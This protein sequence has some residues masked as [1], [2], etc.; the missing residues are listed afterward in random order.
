MEENFLIKKEN[1]KILT[2]IKG[3]CIA[4][5]RITKE[6]LKVKYMYREHP[7]SNFN[8][9]GW[10]FFAGDEGEEYTKNS[11]N[12]NIFE[13]NTICNYDDQI[14]PNLDA[15]IGSAFVKEQNGKFIKENR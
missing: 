12:F 2:D 4:S 3:G 9:T 15:P 14:I 11:N 1:I 7:S 8:D 10:R 6:G 5:N 13:L